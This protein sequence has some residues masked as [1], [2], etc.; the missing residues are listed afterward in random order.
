MLLLAACG[1]SKPTTEPEDTSAAPTTSQ[2]QSNHKHSYGEWKETKPATCQEKGTKERTCECGE[3]QTQ[4]IPMTDHTYGEWHETKAPT[5]SEDGEKERECSVCHKKDTQA[6]VTEGHAWGE[7]TQVAAKAEGY[8]A[9]ETAV[10]S[11]D[12]KKMISI[13]GKS[14]NLVG[15]STLKSDSS[16]PDAMKLNKNG[17]AITYK[18]DYAAAGTGKVYF[19]GAMDYWGDNSGKTFYTGKNNNN[20]TPNFE[21][22][23]NGTVVDI[24][25]K[26]DVTFAEM[27]KKGESSEHSNY[28]N[29]ELVEVGAVAVASGD[30]TITFTRTES[31]NVLVQDIVIVLD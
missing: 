19:Y 16:Y 21:L 9:Y 28:S 6:V 4:D 27:F 24:S 5:C 11:K 18:F 8:V 10:C 31:Y 7:K 12:N 13:A 1:G 15:D 14:G 2:K 26:K 17:N 23:V 30:N 3:K 29:L 20:A 25:S 22:D